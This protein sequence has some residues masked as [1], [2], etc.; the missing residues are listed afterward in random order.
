MNELPAKM[1]RRFAGGLKLKN[2]V[3]VLSPLLIIAAFIFVFTDQ[4]KPD[5]ASIAVIN[6]AVAR[7]LDKDPNEITEADYANITELCIAKTEIVLTSDGPY[8]RYHRVDISDINLL[9]KFVNLEELDISYLTYIQEDI[10]K[11]MS[12]LAKIGILDLSKRTF[13]DLSPLRKLPKLRKLKIHNT[14]LNYIRPLAYLTKLESL[15]LQRTQITE[16]EPLKSLTKLKSLDLSETKIS[17]ITWLS[18]LTE[19]ESLT[20]NNTKISYLEPLKGLTNLRELTLSM[21][22][23]SNVEPVRGMKNLRTLFIDATQVSDIEPLREL[24]NLQELYI[25]LTPV[26]NLEPIKGLP[27]LKLLRME[28]C[29]N[30][31]F[32]QV[33][34]LEAAMPDLVVELLGRQ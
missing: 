26:S 3:L 2:V 14:T 16:I 17:D 1:K 6:A 34:E 8:K 24:T 29:N 31:T 4:N 19:L 22:N 21:T 7:Q 18:S 20:L 10:P 32:E 28:K 27:K 33:R 5:P 11:W 13:L 30:I 12:F 15:D 9:K 25:S 23:I